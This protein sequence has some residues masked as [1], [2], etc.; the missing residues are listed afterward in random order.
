MTTHWETIANCLRAELAD[1][2]GLLHLFEETQR[3][4]FERDPDN[5]L[6]VTHE[7]EEMSRSVEGCR[8]RREEAVA[9]FAR[10]NGLPPT[11]TLRKM[12]PLVEADARP[13]LEAL[14]SEVNTL[15]HRV[16]RISRHNHMMLSRTVQIHQE[17]LQQLRPQSF[18]RTYSPAGRVSVAAAFPSTLQ[19]AG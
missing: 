15:V 2:G 5:V 14:I 19:A 9:A 12:L 16:R 7:I 10:A 8:T 11:T 6:R 3:Y 17:T 4:L 18:T 13:L 1:Y